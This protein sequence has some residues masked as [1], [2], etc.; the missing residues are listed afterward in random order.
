MMKKLRRIL[1]W[2]VVILTVALAVFWFVRPEDVNFEEARAAVPHSAYSRFA[3][4]DGVRLHYQEKGTGEALVL[5][6]G[7]TASTYVW[8]E[9]FEPLAQR[10]HVIAVD[11]KGFGF[12]GKPAGD[13]TR[14]AQSE[15]VIK[16]LDHLKIDRPILCG[17]SMGGEV[18]L[19]AARYHPQRVR[20]LI[21]VDSQGVTV[22]SGASVAPGVA[23]WPVA[24]PLLTAV[25]LTSDSLVR[26]G[27]KLNYF[28]DSKVTDEAVAAY[29]RPLKTRNGQRAAFLARQQVLQQSIEPEV[30]KVQQPTLIIW[31]NED[32]VI[33]VEA[34]RKLNS[35]I[36]GSRLVVFDRCGHV[37]QSEMTDRFLNEVTGFVTSLNPP[38]SE[39][40]GQAAG[41]VAGQM[42]EKP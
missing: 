40:A 8:K 36:A 6:H 21:L 34:G 24:G 42:V 13:Y 35:L 31:G 15:L 27:L 11:M 18:S 9:V 3:D 29:Y 5:L 23:G 7:Y 10:Y 4:I 28:D 16:L 30:G 12:S 26:G 14:R 19:N 39:I 41:Q 2:L 33:P 1:L 38:T 17:N 22:D 25:A 20:A 37:P 32:E